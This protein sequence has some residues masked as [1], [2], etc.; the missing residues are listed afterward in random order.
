MLAIFDCDGVLRSVCINAMYDAYKAIALHLERKPRE[1]WQN[2]DDFKKW[3]NFMHWQNNLERMGMSAGSD[4]SEI[5]RIFHETYDPQIKVFSWAGEVLED[6]EKRHCLAVLSAAPSASVRGSLEK[7][8]GFFSYVLG[9]DDVRMV[10]PDPE[11]IHLLMD[12]TGTK[13]SQTIMIGDTCAD[14]LAGKNAGVMTALVT[15]GVPKWEEAKELKPD[16]IFD[17]PMMLKSL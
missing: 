12:A 14:I 7:V 8:S 9:S 4:Y 3:A 11:G 6:L 13:A 16:F 17:D 1:F 15:W 2:V 10:K 5:I